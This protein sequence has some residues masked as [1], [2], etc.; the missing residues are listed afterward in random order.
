MTEQIVEVLV[1]RARGGDDGAFTCLVE[2]HRPLLERF[3][4]RLIDD[5][6]AA[7]DL[8]QETLIRAHGA[9]ARLE[10]PSR[11]GA[12]LHGIAANLARTWWRRQARAP[13]SLDA[14]GQ[15]QS[16]ERESHAWSGEM[17]GTA[18]PV[19]SIAPLTLLGPEEAALE[20]DRSRQL[21]AAV[22]ALPPALGRAV[23]LYYLDGYS[24]AEV[25]AALQIPVT[26]VKSR[27]FK[28]RGRLRLALAPEHQ[29]ARAAHVTGTPAAPG[30]AR[31]GH[32]RTNQAG[33]RKVPMTA[34]AAPGT[35]GPPGETRTAGSTGAATITGAM[36]PAG[37]GGET[38]RPRN[39]VHCSFCAK[40]HEQV[41]RLIAGPG[42]VYICNRCVARCNE[43]L[44]REGVPV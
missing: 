17:G 13:L 41:E 11:F 20:A 24:Y 42:Q 9:L 19:A 32:P 18:P 34:N 16:G 10:D 1:T 25:A 33:K 15:G 40:P 23:A 39:V 36:D 12:W 38:G 3:C 43:I 8:A 21:R 22:E 4:E 14:L 29:P 6:V 27:L 30:T 28:S 35:A 7:Q 5:R 2:R 31:G 26:T 44:R 37:T